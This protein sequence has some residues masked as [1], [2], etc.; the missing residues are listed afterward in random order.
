[1]SV[2]NAAALAL[3]GALA[4]SAVVALAPA[5]AASGPTAS[6]TNAGETFGGAKAWTQV[7]KKSPN[8]TAWK[9]A[10]ALRT[11][12]EGRAEGLH[13]SFIR[14][15]TS[16]VKGAPVAQATLRIRNT[17]SGSCTATPVELWSTG[18]ISANTTWNT[19]PAQGIKLATV[20]AAK[21]RPGCA[22]GNL[23]FDATALVKEAAA[24]HQAEVT[25][26]LYASDETDP[27]AWKRFDA[28][29]AVLE[30]R[31]EAAP[32]V[33]DPGTSPATA[34]TGGLVG[35]TP[36]S[37]FA[38]V[39][40]P[41]A[42]N[43]TAEFQ[44]FRPGQSAP[45][46]TQAIPALKGKAATWSIPD[47]DLPTGDYTWN[48]RGV[49][50]AGQTSAWSQ[51]CA[52]SVDRTRPQ[53]PPVISSVQ[54]PDAS[55]GVPAQTGN[56]RTPGTFTFAA[57]GV[58]VVSEIVYWTDWDSRR[59]SVAP[60]AAVTLVPPTAGPHTVRAQS[61]D[62]AGNVSDT[63][64]YSFFAKGSP[65]P[66]ASGDLNGDG[67]RDLWTVDPANRLQFRA[68]KGDGTFAA[69]VDGGLTLAAGAQA[70]ASGD[71]TGDG[72]NDL[73]VLEHNDVTRTKM[74]WTYTNDGLGKVTEA[75][76]S[77]LTVTCPVQDPEQG[78]ETADDH[79][80]NAQ[81]IAAAG[82]VDGDGGP[83]LLVRQG[84]E[85]WLYY[86]GFPYLDNTPPVL[87]GGTGWDS[88]TVV[89]PGDVNGDG[90]ADLWLREDATGDVFAVAG[91]KG[92][93]GKLVPASWSAA[94]TK[95]ASGI[96]SAAHPVLGSTGDLTGDGL[97]DLW[98][99]AADGRPVL[100]RG[101]ASGIDA[102]PVVLG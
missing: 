56:A 14:L 67:H 8:R 73:V 53:A 5:A 48:V 66:D 7:S 70:V 94:R 59:V 41:E 36:L 20:T 65:A 49:N 30:T 79:W 11:G 60:G 16:G 81:Q 6:V 99:V 102:T 18:A 100:F 83:D 57:G 58:E 2:R 13:R 25:I 91:A 96:A 9:S 76:R 19:Q 78:C 26:G 75:S 31:T 64:T 10:E 37:L 93:D 12:S 23:E 55:N 44:V 45:L 43:L 38:T 4:A 97:T 46:L 84:S 32:T 89:A 62:K 77:S 51:T 42:G 34:C 50:A 35:N 29:T 72:Y 40:S 47:A 1:M 95:I 63:A 71:W 98:S 39:D 85:L 82:D 74:L 69:P 92:A 27:T 80:F 61:L 101:T 90:A 15:D 86:G 24:K 21:G 33:S 87:V 68:G 3:A 54:F 52:F 28:R 22:A 17:G 88:V